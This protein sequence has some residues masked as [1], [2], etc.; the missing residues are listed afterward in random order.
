M[1]KKIQFNVQYE[2]DM[3]V[4]YKFQENAVQENIIKVLLTGHCLKCEAMDG[5]DS[6]DSLLTSNLLPL[7]VRVKRDP[8]DEC[9]ADMQEWVNEIKQDVKS[10]RKAGKK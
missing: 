4:G 8:L 5:S 3:P 7:N 10:K 6:S 9:L 1:K 2:V